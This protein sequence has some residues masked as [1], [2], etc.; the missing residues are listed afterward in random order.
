M[1]RLTE[2]LPLLQDCTKP[3]L[4]MQ[5]TNMTIFL[6]VSGPPFLCGA[7]G[8]A[9]VAFTAHS[10]HSVSAHR[11][12]AWHKAC[13]HQRFY[14]LNAITSLR[15]STDFFS[16]NYPFLAV[17]PIL[18][19]FLSLWKLLK[20][21]ILFVLCLPRL[22]QALQNCYTFTKPSLPPSE[23]PTLNLVKRLQEQQKGKL[24]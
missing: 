24:P 13:K 16:R 12:M 23:I 11:H 9:H 7:P 14:F 21:Y 4:S 22:G 1:S 15:C 6:P 2:L 3:L 19:L 8:E 18:A 10:V 20:E 5:W 17:P